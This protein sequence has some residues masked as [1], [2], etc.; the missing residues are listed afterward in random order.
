MDSCEELRNVRS[1]MKGSGHEEEA[2]QVNKRVTGKGLVNEKERRR[3]PIEI[4]L[5]MAWH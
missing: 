5:S 4:G 2:F 1:Q 3:L